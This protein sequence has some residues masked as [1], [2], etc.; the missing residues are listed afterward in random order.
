[1]EV[2]LKSIRDKF[3]D[4]F[5]INMNLLGDG[6]KHPIFVSFM[7]N[8]LDEAINLNNKNKVLKLLNKYKNVLSK[9]VYNKLK[10]DF[11]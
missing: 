3:P 11:S 7:P 4:E 8:D 6:Y 9:D 2:N 1:M 10:V 5:I